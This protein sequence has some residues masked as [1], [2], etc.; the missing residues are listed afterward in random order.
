MKRKNNKRNV[1]EKWNTGLQS[2]LGQIIYICSSQRRRQQVGTLA[3]RTMFDLIT[4]AKLF[5]DD[6]TN[7]SLVCLLN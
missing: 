7:E 2:H 1:Y 5:K 4:S 3:N 6:T